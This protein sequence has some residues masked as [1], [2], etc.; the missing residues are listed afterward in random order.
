MKLKAHLL[1]TFSGS[2]KK[3]RVNVVFATLTLFGPLEYD[4][5]NFRFYNLCVFK[6]LVLTLIF[7]GLYYF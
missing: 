3:V 7:L 4:S 2:A 6:G 5:K 1:T